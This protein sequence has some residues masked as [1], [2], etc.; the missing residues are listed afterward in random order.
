VRGVRLAGRALTITL[1][2]LWHALKWW[3]G[4]LGLH[5][6]FRPRARRQEWF[7][8]TV[9]S[10]FRGLGATFIKVG[11][12]MSTRPDL[13]P[14]HVIRALEKLQ[15][16]VGPF[17]YEAV[18]A[19]FVEDFGRLPEEVFD[20]F[21]KEPIASASVAQVHRARKGGRV[22]A[23]KVRR[24]GLLQIV[25]LDLAYMR[26]VGRLLAISPSIRLMA[27][28]ETIEEFGRGIR[29]QLDFTVEADNNRRFSEAFRGD[30]DVMFP[31]LVPE[32]CSERVLTMEYITGQKILQARR[33]DKTRLARVGFRVMLKMIFQDG[34]VHAD[35]HP[36]NIFVTD[37]GKVAILDL[38]LVGELDDEHRRGFARYFAA[39]ARGD[40]KTM[41]NIMTDM[42]PSA[43]RIPDPAGFAR[44]VEAF[45][46]RYFGKRLGEVEVSVVLFDMLQILRRHRV[47]ANPTFTMVNIAIAVTEGIGK[48]LDP[49]IDLMAE[50]LPFFA[51]FHFVSKA[52]APE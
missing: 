50:A 14:P 28:V 9:L 17:P 23:V 1:F 29:M 35:L 18:A 37:D 5:V 47:R 13:F 38:G 36:G 30:P 34:F 52:A 16:Q 45:V 51:Q 43:G 24:P 4:W 19:T 21:E 2:F 22:L 10:L 41:A 31:T 46:A 12:I 7:G 3:V 49:H 40:G 26:G 33:D 44:D 25:E 20:S 15:D 39:W 27:P 8:D 48:Q 11:Q 42:S 32:L 6:A